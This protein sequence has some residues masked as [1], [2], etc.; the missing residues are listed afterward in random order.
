[1]GTTVGRH[2]NH[3]GHRS[4]GT[5]QRKA[6]KVSVSCH[7]MDHRCHSLM[8]LPCLFM[9]HRTHAKVWAERITVMDHRRD[10]AT[11]GKAAKFGETLRK[12][13]TV[14]CHHPRMARWT[15]AKWAKDHRST[16]LGLR[17]DA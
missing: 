3:F 15:H 5:I 1:M 2:C 11:R 10:G 9:D 13:V 6:A 16:S 7:L 17:R 4:T 12:E 14:A 8:D